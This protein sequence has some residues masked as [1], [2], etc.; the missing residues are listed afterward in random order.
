MSLRCVDPAMGEALL[1]SARVGGP[2]FAPHH[3][4]H[5]DVCAA[6]EWRVEQRRRVA[7]VWQSIE[8]D[9]AEVRAARI[10]FMAARPARRRSRKVLTRAATILAVVLAAAV[11]SAAVRVVAVRFVMPIKAETPVVSLDD[12]PKVI[13][14]KAKRVMR[15][16]AVPTAKASPAELS[17]DLA[18]DPTAAAPVESREA[19]APSGP[20]ALEVSVEQ[21]PVAA[22]VAPAPAPAPAPTAASPASAPARVA[23]PALA[24]TPESGHHVASTPTAAAPPRSSWTLAATAMRAGDY[25]AAEAAFSD[26]ASSPD[27]STR[28]AARLARAQVWIAQGHAS[29]ARGT[30]EDLSTSGATPLVRKRAADALDTLP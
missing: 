21:L 17:G 22:P 25:A 13:T 6:C 9:H 23:T 28:D 19:G 15:P 27:A 12:L 2:P 24:S 14:K 8:P 5:L 7:V 10:R 11:A 16:Y 26:L 29:K 30:L 3:L 18:D 4:E 1:E 20:A